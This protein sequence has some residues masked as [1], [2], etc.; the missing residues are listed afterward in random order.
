MEC[1]KEE[2]YTPVVDKPVEN[3]CR[4]TFPSLS[5]NEGYARACAAAFCAQLD[6]QP[7]SCLT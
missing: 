4:L 2:K 5:A 3:T 1:A 6:P 7:R